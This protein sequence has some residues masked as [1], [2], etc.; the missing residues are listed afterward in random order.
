MATYAE[1]HDE[2]GNV[3]LRQKIEVAL[4]VIASE[5]IKGDDDG[6]PYAQT[7][8]Y[9][10]AHAPRLKWA[11]TALQDTGDEAIYLHKFL[12]GSFNATAIASILNATDATV[13]TEIRNVLDEVAGARF[14]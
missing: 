12:F 1:L 3:A 11:L 6:A 5:I 8:D 14:G 4:V 10:T 9:A 2:F 7:P 13:T